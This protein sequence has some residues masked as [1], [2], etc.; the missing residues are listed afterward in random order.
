MKKI[1]LSIIISIL[2]FSCVNNKE[3]IIN[4]INGGYVMNKMIYDNVEVA[5]DVM[6]NIFSFVGNKE[7][8]FK[9]PGIYKKIGKN[10]VY[11]WELLSYKKDSIYV[12][13]YADNEYFN[14]EFRVSFELDY[15]NKLL[16]LILKSDKT[17]IHSSKLLQNFDVEK[18]DWVSR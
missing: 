6:A 17:Y 14:S 2:F 4:K 13:I 3:R 16:N 11:K 12:K 9:P 1:N 8:T 15:E 5:D 10:E 18:N 7:M